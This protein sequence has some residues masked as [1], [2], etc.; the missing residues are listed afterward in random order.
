MQDLFPHVKAIMDNEA[1]GLHFT[2]RYDREERNGRLVAVPTFSNDTWRINVVTG[3][4]E[5]IPG[6]GL[7]K[8]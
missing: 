2:G 6:A 5:P 8:N 3:S 1:K 4:P 7:K